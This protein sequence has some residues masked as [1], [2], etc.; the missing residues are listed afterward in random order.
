MAFDKLSD[1]TSAELPIAVLFEPVV[2]ELREF[3]PIA[4]LLPPVM[5]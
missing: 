1:A 5:L 4:V 2:F 3:E